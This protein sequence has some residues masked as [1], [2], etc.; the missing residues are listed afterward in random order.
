MNPLTSSNNFT[1]STA[2]GLARLNA[3]NLQLD[4]GRTPVAGAVLPASIFGEELHWDARRPQI[5]LAGQTPE[6][7]ALVKKLHTRPAMAGVKRVQLPNGSYLAALAYEDDEQGIALWFDP[8][9]QTGKALLLDWQRHQN[10]YITFM[11]DGFEFSNCQVLTNSLV[12]KLLAAQRPSA[13]V[14]PDYQFV[15]RLEL[16][17]Q[18]ALVS[19]THKKRLFVML[20]EVQCDSFQRL[21]SMLAG[22][23]AAGV[24]G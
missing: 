1:F 18:I 3:G 10:L 24:Q 12:P 19:D 2:P 6:F 14:G 4:A 20:L 9:G 23:R 15:E 22:A 17:Q 11:C 21:T 13:S 8:H 7:E 5:V 16:M